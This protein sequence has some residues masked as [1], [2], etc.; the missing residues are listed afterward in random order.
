MAKSVN[1]PFSDTPVYIISYLW[2]INI[3]CI[4]HKWFFSPFFS[5][6]PH[7]PFSNPGQI[8]FSPG[9]LLGRNCFTD[10]LIPNEKRGHLWCFAIVKSCYIT[11]SKFHIF[12]KNDSPYFYFKKCSKSHLK[13][14]ISQA[15]SI[16]PRGR[17]ILGDDVQHDQGL[18]VR[19]QRSQLVGASIGGVHVSDQNVFHHHL[20]QEWFIQATSLPISL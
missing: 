11:I 14:T 10:R 18:A 20:Q 1:L 15:P 8:H 3:C 2:L 4:Q 9:R 5:H 12:L 16:L 19:Q 6:D 13:K 17:W 7:V